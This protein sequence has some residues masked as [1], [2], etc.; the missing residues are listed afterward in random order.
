MK[1]PTTSPAE[2]ENLAQFMRRFMGPKV[3]RSAQRMI[4]ARQARRATNGRFT[5]DDAPAA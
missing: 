5:S 3:N 2:K 1:K 4:A